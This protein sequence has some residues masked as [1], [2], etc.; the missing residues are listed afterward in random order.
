MGRTS[1]SRRG[2]PE[3]TSDGDPGGDTRIAS[4]ASRKV[5]MQEGEVTNREDLGV[6]SVEIDRGAKED[7][8]CHLGRGRGG[9]NV[10]EVARCCRRFHDG[11]GGGG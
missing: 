4:I 8:D 7:S 11:G 5:E 6:A 9:S 10:I 2:R 1:R 3:I